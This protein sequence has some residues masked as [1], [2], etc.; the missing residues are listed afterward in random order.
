MAL[1]TLHTHIGNNGIINLETS[2]ALT[3]E[4]LHTFPSRMMPTNSIQLSGGTM[5]TYTTT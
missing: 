3:L 4:A 2:H 1:E 5:P